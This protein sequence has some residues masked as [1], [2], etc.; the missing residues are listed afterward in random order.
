[1]VLENKKIMGERKEN[2]DATSIKMRTLKN[3]RKEPK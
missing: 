2:Q 3:A 1:M